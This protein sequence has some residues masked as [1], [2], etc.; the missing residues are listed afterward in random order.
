MPLGPDGRR[1]PQPFAQPLGGRPGLQA[2]LGQPEPVAPAQ[3]QAQ[4]LAGRQGVGDGGGRG[5]VI[6]VHGLHCAQPGRGPAG[7]AAHGA[8]RNSGLAGHL[9]RFDAR[10][11]VPVAMTAPPAHWPAP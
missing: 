11:S 4:A 10:H 1:L 9:F 3:L 7:T 2:P 5:Q 8:P 6:G